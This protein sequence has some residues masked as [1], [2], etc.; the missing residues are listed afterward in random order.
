MSAG[1]FSEDGLPFSRRQGGAAADA[2]KRVLEAVSPVQCSLPHVVES[3]L[4]DFDER[5]PV[6]VLTISDQLIAINRARY[7]PRLHSRKPVLPLPR[8]SRHRA[9]CG[10]SC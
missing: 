3:E 6:R 7:R 8:G 1:H 2:P 4:P 9:G 5:V 10:T